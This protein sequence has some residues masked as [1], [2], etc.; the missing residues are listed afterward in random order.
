[1]DKLVKLGM[2]IIRNELLID[3][4]DI[5]VVSLVGVRVTL[6]DTLTPTSD[7]TANTCIPTYI[8]LD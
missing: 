1:M 8:I 6:S 2:D 7:T 3:N 5:A 4:N